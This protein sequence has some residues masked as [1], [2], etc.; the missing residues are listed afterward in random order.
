V[1]T[2]GTDLNGPIVSVGGPEDEYLPEEMLEERSEAVVKALPEPFFSKRIAILIPAYNEELTIGSVVLDALKYSKKVIVINDGSRDRTSEV[3]RMAGAQVI[4][5][6]KNA[7]KAAALMRGFKAVG[8]KG[9]SAVV[10]MDGDGQH[11]ASDISKL[12]PPILLGDADLV[13]GSRFMQRENGIPRYRQLGQRILNRITNAGSRSK[14]SDT[15]S[16]FRALSE[17]AIASMDFETSGYAVEQ[18]M[19]V[20]FAERGLRM[21]EVPIS[22]RYNVPNGHKQGSIVMG[23]G[24]FGNIISTVGYKRPLLLFG[25]PGLVLTTIGVIVGLLALF[26]VFFTDSWMLQ[27]LISG[28]FVILGSTLCVSAL[29]LNSLSQL[30]RMNRNQRH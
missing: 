22:V 13:I 19:I 3:A 20:H 6:E 25:V 1:A 30:I 24:L 11:L 18:D 9:Y 7:G 28:F 10:M 4:D 21:V 8:N 15:Q 17:R 2:N 29:T 26:D 5:I 27:G 16:G 14:V 12:L 23:L